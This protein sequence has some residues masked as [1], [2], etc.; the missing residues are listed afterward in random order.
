MKKY[1]LF[2]FL[3][4]FPFSTLAQERNTVNIYFFHSNTC[5]H[6]KAEGKFLLKI[7]KKYDYIQIYRYEVHDQ[8]NQEY[9][10]ALEEEYNFSLTSVP[11]TIVGNQTI[12]GYQEE[13]T[14]REI[15]QYV[16]YFSS[17]YYQDKLGERLNIKTLPTYQPKKDDLSLD[18]YLKN[19]DDK[20]LG[21]LPVGDL[22]NDTN[23]SLLGFLSGI[24]F[25]YLFSLLFL[26]LLIKKYLQDH[27]R[28]I[29]MLL[30][31][32]FLFIE[33][34]YLFHKNLL[35]FFPALLLF[36]LLTFL[37]LKNRQKKYFLYQIILIMSFAV[38]LLK[39]KNKN[40]LLL[41]KIASVYQLLGGEKLLYY[42]CYFFSLLLVYCISFCLFFIILENFEKKD[43][44]QLKKNKKSKRKEKNNEINWKSLG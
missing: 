7:E 8:K 37:S 25:Y 14:D 21:F 19:I 35:F 32:S 41:Q 43:Y 38:T 1:L 30:Y 20:I 33:E 22:D 11:V 5:S 15:M 9:I 31:L 2:F 36:L 4:F 3:F 44:Q 16:S 27:D 28:L 39:S 40:V 24:N 10:Q 34:F 23:A 18:T 29:S 6:C 26:L 17:Y 42:G 12:F 13:K